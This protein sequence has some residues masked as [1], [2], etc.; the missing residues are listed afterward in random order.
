M[1]T[2]TKRRKARQL[3][4]AQEQNVL[5]R[6]YKEEVKKLEEMVSDHRDKGV[7]LRQEAN[8]QK[9]VIDNFA[10]ALVIENEELIAR[11]N[12]NIQRLLV[13]RPDKELGMNV[14]ATTDM[15]IKNT[16]NRANRFIP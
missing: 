3:S 16:R 12:K 13:L 14:A 7:T 8:Y 15:Q 4:P 1:N 9:G 10:N 5:L 6:K 2:T 11:V